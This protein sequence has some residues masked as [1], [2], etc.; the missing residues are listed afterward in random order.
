M[1]FLLFVIDTLDFYP[2]FYSKEHHIDEEFCI[3]NHY[4]I[5]NTSHLPK[6]NTTKQE[7]F[8]M[9]EGKVSLLADRQNFVSKHFWFLE[10][11]FS[12]H[13]GKPTR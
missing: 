9:Y 4:N 8:L 1:H 12:I 7:T 13:P 2:Y 10:L 5:N 6:R 3:K 11:R